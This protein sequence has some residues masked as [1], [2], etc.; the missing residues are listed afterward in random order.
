MRFERIGNMSKKL[1]RIFSNSPIEKHLTLNFDSTKSKLDFINALKQSSITGKPITTNGTSSA[2]I[3]CNDSGF[4]NLHDSASIA[5]GQITVYP[6]YKKFTLPNTVAEKKIDLLYCNI[7]NGIIVRSPLNSSVCFEFSFD[8]LTNSAKFNYSISVTSAKSTNELV[9]GFRVAKGAFDYF[10]KQHEHSNSQVVKITR[11]I[12]LSYILFLRLSIIEHDLSLHFDPASFDNIYDDA[13]DIHELYYAI[14]ENRYIRA[15]WHFNS[16]DA[17]FTLKSNLSE[18]SIGSSIDCVFLSKT[19]YSIAGTN[20]EIYTVNCLGNAIIKRIESDPNGAQTIYYGDTDEKPLYLS[21]RG[22]QSEEL[23]QK[24][25][26]AFSDHKILYTQA[27][28]AQNYLQQD[29]KS[30]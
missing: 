3:F 28:T 11:T 29:L 19:G 7:E 17:Y 16:N 8:T 15:P 9:E 10:F 20:I 22:F 24:E 23:A 13:S 18:G 25:L 1:K 27:L 6:S 14:H 12:N 2:D 4:L 21:Y 26:D 5:N 30:L